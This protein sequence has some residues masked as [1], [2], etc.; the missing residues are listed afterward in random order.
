[1]ISC[2]NGRK[3]VKPKY[4]F[5]KLSSGGRSEIIRGPAK[6]KF[7]GNPRNEFRCAKKILPQPSF[8]LD[9]RKSTSKSRAH[10]KLIMKALPCLCSISLAFLFMA[11]Q[12]R[13]A[14][15]AAAPA[16]PPYQKPAS[17]K[18]TGKPYLGSV[19]R[20]DPR[21]DEI[22]ARDAKMEKLAQG[23]DWSE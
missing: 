18:V 23:F 15:T 20:L 5:S 12:S 14:G 6:L 21:L 17:F 4:C 7:S 11:C 19:E 22:L 2:W 1:M 13:P 3:E 16:E 10:P 8:L 9:R